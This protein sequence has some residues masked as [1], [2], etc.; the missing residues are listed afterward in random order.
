MSM[1]QTPEGRGKRTE[2]SDLFSALSVGP[3]WNQCQHSK[4]L[5]SPHHLH[6]TGDDMGLGEFLRIPKKFR[7]RTRSKARSEVIPI[8]GPS[9][10]NPVASRTSEST[11]DLGI[12]RSAL[13]KPSISTSPGRGFKGIQT[14]FSRMNHLTPHATQNVPTRIKINLFPA[15]SKA[16]TWGHQAKLLNQVHL[17]RLYRT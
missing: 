11:P 15:K 14:Y 12:G 6:P 7:R 8:E 1:L 5:L 4:F 3:E 13:L 10:D 16:S 17:M 2:D 9:N